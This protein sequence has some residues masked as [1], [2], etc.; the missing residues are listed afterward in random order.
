MRRI[1]IC[2]SIICIIILFS[3]CK[4]KEQEEE[5]SEVKLQKILTFESVQNKVL[6]NSEDIK[7]Y[8]YHDASGDIIIKADIIE[9]NEEDNKKME[10]QVLYDTKNIQF[11]FTN[12]EHLIPFTL[13][14]LTT[15]DEVN[16][17]L[18][19]KPKEDGTGIL[20]SFDDQYYKTWEYFFYLF[21]YYNAYVTFFVTGKPTKFSLTAL[22]NGHDIGYHS[23]N[24]KM[25]INVS[26]EV[27]K[28][29]TTGE[30][31]NF[32]SAGIPLLSFA[33]PYGRFHDWMNDELLMTYKITRGF[34]NNYHVYRKTEIKNNFIY[35]KSIDQ[36][37]NKNDYDFVKSINMMLRAVKFTE[38]DLV[39]PLSSHNIRSN[40]DC[41]ISPVRLEYLLKTAKDLKIKFYRY[42][43]FAE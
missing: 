36:Y 12:D 13:K 5:S 25:L 22:E 28:K 21:E 30:V 2:V 16:D 37:Y 43:D 3:C 35:S 40:T 18:L 42:C 8:I 26:D 24:H 19:W 33:Y 39:L 7:K 6:Q 20:L 11:N 17:S 14:C 15:N 1:I 29:E 4:K 32:R 27:F 34:D 23:L 31:V 10:F 41:G 9:I 38:Q